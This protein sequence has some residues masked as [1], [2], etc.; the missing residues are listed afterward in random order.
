MAYYTALIDEWKT[1]PGKTTDEKL[2]AVNALTVQVAA[3]GIALVTPSQILNAIV[4][5]DLELLTQLQIAQLT[6]LLSGGSVDASKG[7]SIRVGIQSFFGGKTQTLANLTELFAAADQPVTAP[8][9]PTPVDQGGGGL[10][11]PVSETDLKIAGL[12]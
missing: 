1:L 9:W 11:G 12:S 6:L 5:A 7:S 10:S 8:W 2:A 3:Q 4:F